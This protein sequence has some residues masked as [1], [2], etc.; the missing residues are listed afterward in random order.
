MNYIL[1][2]YLFIGTLSF[3]IGFISEKIIIMNNKNNILTKTK[4]KNICYYFVLLFFIG[5]ILHFIYEFLGI[6]KWQC[7]KI[8]KNGVCNYVCKIVV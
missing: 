5:I 6:N 8:C 1:L 2:D 7:E 3:I 4:E